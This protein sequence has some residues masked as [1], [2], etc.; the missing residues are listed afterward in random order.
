MPK[1]GK[2]QPFEI[3]GVIE[4]F[5]GP[6][7]T[8]AAR[9]RMIDFMAGAGFN[10]YCYAPKDDPFHRERWREPYPADAFK[11]LAQLISRC[12]AR[13]VDFCWAV[14]PGLSVAY[15]NAKLFKTLADKMLS[16]AD[17]GVK[18]FALLLDD[19]PPELAHAADRKRYASL[20]HAH[21]D[22]ANRLHER[23]LKSM[24]GCT[25][26][27][28]P[29]DYIGTQSTP[30]LEAVGPGM[31]PRIHI[32][33]T[34]PHVVSRSITAAD[35]RAMGEILRRKPLLWD[36]YPV[37]DYNRNVLNL[38]PLRNRD[39]QLGSLLSGCFANP[40]NE[41]EASKIPLRTMADYMKD[42]GGYD[43]DASWRNAVRATGRNAR[44]AA[45]LAAIGDY[46]SNKVFP[47][48]P[49]S[50]AWAQIEMARNGNRRALLAAM[51]KLH[52]ISGD[53]R[54]G[55]PNRRLAKDLRLYARKLERLARAITLAHEIARAP[56]ARKPALRKQIAPL[57]RDI[58]RDPKIV[59]AGALQ[60]YLF[61][62]A[63]E[64]M[65]DLVV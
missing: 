1:N 57:L 13:G 36:N 10:A 32:F 50:P 60:C 33:W 45:T 12:N 31:D 22:Y 38:G 14:S 11:K 40:M 28:C 7:W 63:R 65:P 58:R 51:R 55:V 4:G 9:L 3:R 52:N 20:G 39:P 30:Y 19:I 16:V 56:Q 47:D 44:G 6:P 25:L 37:N 43:P 34:G 54:Q 62:T 42:P 5:Y 15:T 2:C 23:L 26:F 21:A 24:P 49:H 27:F 17:K 64:I 35:A 53:L 59:C 29:T 18:T 61:D 48:Q 46:C 41:A 8:H